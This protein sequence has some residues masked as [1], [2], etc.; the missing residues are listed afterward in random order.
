MSIH[1]LA[2]DILLQVERKRKEAGW[3]GSADLHMA[4][5]AWAVLASAFGLFLLYYG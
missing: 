4:K 1:G 3:V 5:P 2:G